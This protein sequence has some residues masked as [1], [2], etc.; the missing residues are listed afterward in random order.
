[1]PVD[2]ESTGP[3][4]DTRVVAG[5]HTSDRV[6]ALARQSSVY[7]DAV[8][9]VQEG[10]ESVGEVENQEGAYNSGD[11]VQV[12]DGGTDNKGEGPVERSKGVPHPAALA[13]GDRG[14]IENLLE[15]LHVHSLHADVHV[16]D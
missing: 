10:R 3:A 1:M 12:G 15:D 9:D 7:L 4:L 2:H 16:H 13:G 11:A 6:E 14:E 8:S 5:S